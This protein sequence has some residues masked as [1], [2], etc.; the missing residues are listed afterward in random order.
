MSGNN[1]LFGNRL[2]LGSTRRKATTDTPEQVVTRM[3]TRTLEYV[4]KH[5]IMIFDRGE[6]W[7]MLETAPNTPLLLIEVSA[8]YGDETATY[9]LVRTRFTRQHLNSRVID[10]EHV[11]TSSERSATQRIFNT[12]HA[13]LQEFSP[14]Q[15]EEIVK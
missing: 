10:S 5:S 14:A 4:N 11:Q 6:G 13:A 8:T 2:Q 7:L 3:I 9:I 12:M 1:H 15:N